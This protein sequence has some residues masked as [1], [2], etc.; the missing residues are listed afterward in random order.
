[1]NSPLE[2]NSSENF[3]EPETNEGAQERVEKGDASELVRQGD[4]KREEFGNTQEQ[5]EEQELLAQEE[6]A[7]E[8]EK[9]RAREYDDASATAKERFQNRI[10]EEAP[11]VEELRRTQQEEAIKRGKKV[12][13]QKG[14]FNRLF[15]RE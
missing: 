1:M 13:P 6:L 7:R 8:R 10:R 3:P 15:G 9:L 5:A 2:S 4:E 14:F 11:L 12:N